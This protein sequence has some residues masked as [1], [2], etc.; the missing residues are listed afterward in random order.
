MKL[1]T[2]FITHNRLELT[3]RAIGSYLDT[4]TVPYSFM[5]VDNCS[6]DGTYAWLHEQFE[7]SWGNETGFF[8]LG[9]NY[10]PGYAT[11]LGWEKAPDDA[12]HLQRADNDFIF[13]P[14]WCEE[15]ERMFQN[16]R[17]GQL[18]MRTDEEELF[19]KWNVGGNNI[20]RRELWDKGLRYDERPWPQIRDEVSCG[21]S[22]D[23]LFS[24]AVKKMGYRWDRVEKPCIINIDEKDRDDPYYQRSF[25]DRGIDINLWT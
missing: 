21:S 10:Y 24:P 18:G 2:V 15:V 19:A 12:T 9:K 5:V 17:L 4:V 11:N 22:E 7:K 1:H 3:K 23:S 14:N 16:R 6:E 25:A 8:A 13:R 20:I